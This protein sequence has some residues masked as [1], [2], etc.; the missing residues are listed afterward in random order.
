MKILHVTEAYGGGVTSAI[1]TYVKHSKQFKHYL[2]ACVRQNDKTGEEDDGRFEEKYL[3]AR[4]F[5]ALLDLRDLISKLDPDVIHLHSTYAGFFVRLMPYIDKK[6][7]VYTPHAFAF[8]RNQNPLVLC[9]YYYIE[10]VLAFRTQ[11]I[12]GC[13]RDEMLIAQKLIAI[14]QSAELINICDP[15]AIR[16]KDVACNPLPVIAMLGRVSEQKG[17]D[18]FASVACKLNG[19][20]KFVWIGGGDDDGERLLRMAGVEVTGWATRTEVVKQLNGV[21][22]YFHSAAWDGF[23]VSVLEA[24]ELEKPIILREIGPFVA[25]GLNTVKSVDDAIVEILSFIGLQSGALNR[26]SQNSNS[27]KDYHTE[28]NL[29]CALEKLYR[30]FE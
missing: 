4:R 24:A 19:L 20:A 13:G 29:E 11:V 7:I 15:I 1:N 16:K 21:D 6:K 23:P 18:Y 14:E 8:L 28:I 27:I 5:S 3:V 10:K 17:Y 26:T 12:A 9:A 2:F 30:S 22:L 25:E